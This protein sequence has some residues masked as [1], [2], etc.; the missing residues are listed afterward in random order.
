M[1]VIFV[2]CRFDYALRRDVKLVWFLAGLLVCA[3]RDQVNQ[4]NLVLVVRTLG[5]GHV[6]IKVC[7]HNIFL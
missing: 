1:V 4:V 2:L 5:N 3:S 7:S 6:M